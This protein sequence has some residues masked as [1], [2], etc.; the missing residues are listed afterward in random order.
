MAVSLY[1]PSIV[2]IRLRISALV[3]RTSFAGYY[4][5]FAR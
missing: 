1:G 5:G 3:L 2:M 4:D